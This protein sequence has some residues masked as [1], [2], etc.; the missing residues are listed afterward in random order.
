MR[1]SIKILKHI[2]KKRIAASSLFLAITVSFIIT[3]HL[4]AMFLLSVYQRQYATDNLKVKKLVHNMN[5]GIT[6]I[7]QNY[8]QF[9]YYKMHAVDL[10]GEQ[11]DSILIEKHYWGWYDQVELT[12]ID[13][14]DSLH[15][16]IVIG[17]AAVPRE[18]R[19]AIYIA[20]HSEV[21][22]INSDSYIKGNIALPFRGYKSKVGLGMPTLPR[23]S[24][25][26]SNAQLPVLREDR[27]KEFSSLLKLLKTNK[28]CVEP[29]LKRNQLTA[30][31]NIVDCSSQTIPQEGFNM[32]TILFSSTSLVI[33]QGYLLSNVI[34]YAPSVIIK[35]GFKGDVQVFCTDSIIVED[36]CILNYPSTLTL[37]KQLDDSHKSITIGQN[38]SIGGAIISIDEE[39]GF[40]KCQI[41]IGKQSIVHGTI[42]SMGMLENHAKI[43]GTIMS[44]NVTD[45]TLVN[46]LGTIWI[47]AT[48]NPD[49]YGEPILFSTNKT[50]EFIK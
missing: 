20:N 48:A 29:L 9:E 17:S 1:T 46:D 47:D 27:I 30:Y 8:E 34:I 42:Y 14:L 6:F 44:A 21:I 10:F 35:S 24:A 18:Q 32:P 45:G 23:L 33:N 39:P 38:C 43:Y 19:T 26:L 37:I 3:V 11:S 13:A 22:N 25:S 12:S 40:Q 49:I 5:E 2:F 36:N 41:R 28:D 7:L 31:E 15:K 50:Y 16:T 4:S